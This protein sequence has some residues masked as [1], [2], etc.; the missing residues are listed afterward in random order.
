[1]PAAFLTTRWSVV[2]RAGTGES[3]EAL[4]QLCRDYWYPL[5]AF[6]RRRGFST[7]DAQDLTQG[8]FAHVLDGTL[9]ARARE[10][11]G[12]FRSYILR[13][14]QHYVANEQRHSGTQRRGGGT[15]F[16]AIDH[17]EGEQRFALEPVAAMTPESQFER[18]WA[19]AL[20]ER[21]MEQLHTEYRHA[22]R[23][24]LFEKLQPYLAGKGQLAGYE[25]LGRALAMS[26]SAV[27]VAI[28]RMRRR[29]GELLR[30]E[31]AQTISSFEDVDEELV[32][33]HG[34]VARV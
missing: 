15:T 9:L 31:I 6:V 29:Y 3:D 19:F 22:N 25:S 10:E 26:T 5:Y 32:Y 21:V 1:M 27:A 34:I 20:L 23:L 30:Q 16:V 28:H 24:E 7:H 8:F 17:L 13:A 14:L 2:L 12:R 4:A 18:S 11:K 33:L